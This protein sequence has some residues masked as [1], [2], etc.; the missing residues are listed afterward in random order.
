MVV[1]P[2]VVQMDPGALQRVESLFQEQIERGDHPGAVLA[3][4]MVKTFIIAQRTVVHPRA[5]AAISSVTRVRLQQAVR[6]TV[7]S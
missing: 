6:V 1:A 5:T 3:V 4:V 7:V 2:D